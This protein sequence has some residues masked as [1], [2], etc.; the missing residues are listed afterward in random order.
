MYARCH[1]ADLALDRL[2]DVHIENIFHCIVQWIHDTPV[3]PE[4][5]TSVQ[6]KLRLYGLY[7]RACGGP[8]PEDSEHV[9]PLASLNPFQAA[10]TKA[11]HDAY[12]SCRNM[13]KRQ[14]MQQYIHLVA[15]QPTWFGRQC[16]DLILTETKI[17]GKSM[18]S[19]PSV[20]SDAIDFHQQRDKN[21]GGI[22]H[23]K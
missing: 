17:C 12:A 6:D 23:D 8:Y 3:T 9:N 1:Q 14:A 21:H 5:R 18:P 20:V 13:T 22:M 15:R 11:K 7:K 4:V 10:A 16:K 19:S 2:S